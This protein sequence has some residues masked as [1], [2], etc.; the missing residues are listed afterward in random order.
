M[1]LKELRIA[2]KESW[3][4][5]GPGFKGRLV[6]DAEDTSEIS[7]PLDDEACRQMIALAAKAFAATAQASADF[8]KSEAEGLVI[9]NMPKLEGGA[10]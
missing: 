1:Q 10:A 8:L 4:K 3:E 5:G 9:E 7:I 6:T 2:R